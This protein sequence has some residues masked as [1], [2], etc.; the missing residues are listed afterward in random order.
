MPALPSSGYLEQLSGS[1]TS[2]V[3]GGGVASVGDAGGA[4]VFAWHLPHS[5]QICAAV[6]AEVAA[7]ASAKLNPCTA[8]LLVSVVQWGLFLSAYVLQPPNPASKV[9]YPGLHIGILVVVVVVDVVFSNLSAVVVVVVVVVVFSNVPA[10]PLGVV[11]SEITFSSGVVGVHA[12][13]S[14]HMDMAR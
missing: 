14:T 1:G 6:S 8:A 12:P 2:A 9:A 5:G 10:E 3:A 11:A 13:H 4:I 7:I